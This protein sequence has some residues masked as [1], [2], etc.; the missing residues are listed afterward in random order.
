VIPQYFFTPKVNLGAAETMNLSDFSMWYSPGAGVS[1]ILFGFVR[2]WRDI[3]GGVSLP[4]AARPVMLYCAGPGPYVWFLLECRAPKLKA[5]AACFLLS[6][7]LVPSMEIQFPSRKVEK[8][9]SRGSHLKAVEAARRLDQA[10]TFQR[11][12]VLVAS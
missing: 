12:L 5:G 10:M 1:M 7:I 9:K 2:D 8:G 6:R 3:W 11:Q 4:F